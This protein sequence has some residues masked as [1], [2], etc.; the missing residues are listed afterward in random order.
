MNIVRYEGK[1]YFDYA[2]YWVDDDINIFIGGRMTGKTYSLYKRGIVNCEYDYN[3]GIFTRR[4]GK[5]NYPYCV[6]LLPYTKG[7]ILSFISIEDYQ[8]WHSNI[9]NY[10]VRLSDMT[11]IRLSRRF[12]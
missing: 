9:L 1:E 11:Y 8:E 2:K 4:Y 12:S 3:L 6:N 10:L 5:H 7:I